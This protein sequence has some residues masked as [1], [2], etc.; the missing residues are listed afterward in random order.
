MLACPQTTPANIDTS[1]NKV[2][3][4][5]FHTRSKSQTRKRTVMWLVKCAILTVVTMQITVLRYDT[6]R[7]DLS[8]IQRN[9]LSLRSYTITLQQEVFLP[10]CNY[11]PDY[12][13]PR[14]NHVSYLT[15]IPLRPDHKGNISYPLSTTHDTQ[16][17]NS[18]TNIHPL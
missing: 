9:R 8:S 7:Y 17:T 10:V 3:C 2:H 16:C 13:K 1:Y 4:S 6:V 5:F 14:L 11:L 12:T 18:S 15:N